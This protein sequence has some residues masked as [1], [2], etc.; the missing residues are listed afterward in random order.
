M[1]VYSII[2]VCLIGVGVC[3]AIETNIPKG[4]V[5]IGGTKIIDFHVKQADNVTPQTMT[6]WSLYFVI[7][8]GYSTDVFEITKTSE[9]GGGIIISSA[10]GTDDK[11]SVYLLRADT[12]DWPDGSA[13]YS[14][15]RS[16]DPNDEPLA[17]GTI[18][19]T[20]VARQ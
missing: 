4:Q 18:Y 7:R 19:L 5:F 11:A 1:Y 8:A 17:Y 6:G 12:L 13:Q 20:K 15:W 10:E 14:L 16:D 9:V 2:N 3:M